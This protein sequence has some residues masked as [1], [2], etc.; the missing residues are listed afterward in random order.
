[1]PIN[2]KQHAV[3]GFEQDEIEIVRYVLLAIPAHQALSV[4]PWFDVSYY[5]LTSVEKLKYDI[6]DMHD[7]STVA[8]ENRK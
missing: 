8:L 7:Q 5:S 2:L 6:R 4:F 3:P 1:M